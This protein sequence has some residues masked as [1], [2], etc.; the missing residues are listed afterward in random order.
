MGLCGAARMQRVL[1][2][3]KKLIPAGKPGSVFGSVQKRFIN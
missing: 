3:S 2:T 1:H